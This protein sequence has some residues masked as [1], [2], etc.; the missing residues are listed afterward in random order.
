MSIPQISAT[1]SQ[2]SIDSIMQSLA[3]IGDKLP[4]LISLK[5]ED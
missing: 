4:F 2:E 5:E 1:I 3:S